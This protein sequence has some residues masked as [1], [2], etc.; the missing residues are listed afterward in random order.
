MDST[1]DSI[2]ANFSDVSP[3]RR[4]ISATMR[5]YSGES[6]VA[7]WSSLALSSPSKSL[8]MRRVIS[9]RSLFDEVKP[10]KGQP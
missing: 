3:S 9:S 7:Y 8:M 10:M 6:V 4:A 2:L 5:W 1:S